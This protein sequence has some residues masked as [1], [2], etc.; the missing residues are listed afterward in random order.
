MLRASILA[1]SRKSFPKVEP[2]YPFPALELE[3]LEKWR[4]GDIFRRS[5]EERA[6]GGE[7]VF[8]EGPP[9]ANNVPHVGHAVT[10]VVKDLIPRYRAMQGD[11]VERKG[12]W[13]THGLPVEI[14]IEKKLGFTEK[15]QIEAYGIAEFNRQCLDSVNAYEK[16]WRQMIERLGHW[17]DLDNPYFT[18]TNDYIESVWWSLAEHA[19]KDR[20]YR[21]Y[22]IQPYC[23]RCGTS[24]S[25]HEVAQNYKDIEDPS[26]WVLFPT[27]AGQSISDLDGKAWDLGP[28]VQIL[29][30]TTTP[31]TLLSH[32]G[33][34]VNPEMVYRLVSH[35]LD[36]DTLLLLGD[37]LEKVVP[38]SIQRD[39]GKEMVDLRTLEAIARFRGRDLE[40]VLYER[41]FRVE[42]PDQSDFH[43]SSG[44]SSRGPRPSDE[45]GWQVVLASY[46]TAEEGTGVV[47]TAPLFGEDDY[48]T[49]LLYDL[50]QMQAIDLNG[51]VVEGVGLEDVAGLWFKDADSQLVR[52]LRDEGRLLHTQRVSH[53]YPFCWRCDQP[54]I[55]YAT[56]SWFI[57]VTADKQ[58]LIDNNRKVDWHPD[59]V[60]QGRFGDWLENLVD[61]AL[62]RSRYW[63]TPLPVWLC[64]GCEARTVIGSYAEL[65][66]AAGRELPDDPYDRTQF[67]PH[68]PFIDELEWPCTECDGGR[69]QRVLEV[70][71]TWYDSGSMPFAQLHYPFE[72]K[73]LFERRFPADFI[74]EAVDQTRGWFYTLHCLGSLLFDQPAFKHCIVLGHIG[75]ESGR[76]MSKRLGN[77]VDPMEVIEQSGADALRWYFYINNPEL[78]ARFS[79]RLVREAAQ[80]FLLPLWNAV[81]FFSIYA[82]LDE[83]SPGAPQPPF[84]ARPALDRWILLRLNRLIEDMTEALDGYR[85]VDASRAVETFLGD[86]TNWY[87][88]RSRDRFWATAEGNE[89]DKESAYQAL[90]EVLTTLC[91]LLA[92]FTPFVADEIYERLERSQVEEASESVHLRAWPSPVADRD[93]E[94]LLRSISDVQRIVRLGHAARN[95]HGARTR[96][97]LESV[98]VV[99]ADAGLRGSVGPYEALVLEELNIRRVDWAESRAEYVHHEV[100]PI[101]PKCGPRFGKQMPLVKRALQD[102]DGDRLTEELEERGTVSIEIEGQTVELSGEEV[103][104]RLVER[105]GLAVQGDGDLLVALDI[106]LNESLISEGLAREIV[107][108]L[109]TARKDADLDY[110]D[111]I[112]VRYR[113]D[114]ELQDVV[115]RH[116]DWICSETLATELLKAGEA[117]SDLADAPIEDLSFSLS[118]EAL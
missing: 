74:S 59:H 54:L 8:Y 111:R 109:Q 117:D 51:R 34:A 98:T 97:P 22:K 91:R 26:V 31:W 46:V 9:T 115:E 64:D 63:G 79:A 15:A 19:K 52:R 10:R 23:G 112:R 108:R 58:K 68:R 69:M 57:R 32:A 66:S 86:L 18:Y 102:A 27:R 6:G 16:D 53:S 13:D 80:N 118:I 43:A 84:A 76:K 107:H 116:T 36:S 89:V 87:V 39:E 30:W 73:E 33:L 114:Q 72:N 83:W 104:V 47:H 75:D 61:W 29:A 71:D 60:G 5:L 62:S 12:G 44:E 24:L 103:E 77:V 55:Y 4:Q 45:M 92:P 67:D 85:V 41:P 21:G 106:Q 100:V 7:F 40:G 78:N 70:I 93:D 90:Y 17:I 94:S 101:F 25:S 81:S 56:N 96:Q 14:E 50:P 49:G 110:A 82:N 2:G 20:L 3:R 48:Q 28:G 99:T 113:A 95:A 105:E 88:R 37:E 38:L 42:L 35:P 11:Y 65:F 1:M